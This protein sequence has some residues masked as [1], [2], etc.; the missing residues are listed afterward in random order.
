MIRVTVPPECI[1]KIKD[2]AIFNCTLRNLLAAWSMWGDDT[3]QCT[4]CGGA[5]MQSRTL[6]VR[7]AMSLVIEVDRVNHGRTDYAMIQGC[8]K[9]PSTT[10]FPELSSRVMP[11]MYS[12]RAVVVQTQQTIPDGQYLAYV[13]HDNE[14]WYMIQ[15]HRCE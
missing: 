1:R 3:T 6:V 13:R 15:D 12:L 4:G 9:Y 14:G 11:A 8:F 5:T 10:Q 2:R 7:G